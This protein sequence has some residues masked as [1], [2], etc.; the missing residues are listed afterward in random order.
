MVDAYNITYTFG[1]TTFHVD[2]TCDNVEE[3]IEVFKDSERLARAIR[4]EIPTKVRCEKGKETIWL[5]CPECGLWLDTVDLED[6]EKG[7][8]RR[9]YPPKYCQCCGQR[10]VWKVD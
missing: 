10:L 4:H 8:I 3:E 2:V 9:P 7:R 5:H 1:S 6:I